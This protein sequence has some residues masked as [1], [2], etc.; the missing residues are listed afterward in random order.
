MQLHWECTV[1]TDVDNAEELSAALTDVL[2]NA[3]VRVTAHGFKYTPT[4]SDPV[5]ETPR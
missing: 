1:L 3:D 4:T 2:R 5:L